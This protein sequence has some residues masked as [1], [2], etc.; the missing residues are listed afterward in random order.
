VAVPGV[1]DGEIDL[2]WDDNTEPD[3]DYY[4]VERA[5][6]PGFA[7]SDSFIA[8]DSDYAD[9][10]LV[11]GQ[12]YYYRVFANDL[13][14]H[15]SDASDIASAVAADGPPAAPTGLVAAPG[16]GEGE[17]T[18]SWNANSEPD[19]DHYRLER[20]LAPDFGPGT[21]PFDLPE[22]AY[23]DSGLVP[24]T[25]Y[26]YRVIAVD[27]GMNESPP[28]DV[29]SEVALDL[30]P[31]PP[32]GLTA[33]SGPGEGEIHLSW[34]ANPEPDID[35][36]LLERAT[37]PE[38]EPGSEPF[39]T[40]ATAYQDSGLVPGE[41]YYYR[42]SAIDA[43]EH[44]SDPSEV[45]SAV[46]LDVAPA[47]PTG[48][49]AAPSGDW[50]V[51][52]TWDP[53]TEPDLDRYRLER[54]T[55]DVFGAGTVSFETTEES[56]LDSGLDVG[57]TYYY[58]LFA[59]DVLENESAP[60]DTVAHLFEGTDVPEELV[61]SVSFIGP[62]PFSAEA[63]VAYTVPSDGASVTMSVFDVRG[64][65]VRTLVDRNHAGGVYRAAW[66]GRDAAGHQVAS[67]IYFF[68]IAVGDLERI[69]K[70]VLLR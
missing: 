16:P 61:A 34:N 57:L 25:L 47:A 28:S 42:V 27:A 54:D 1:A 30:V 20:C 53:N 8:P 9:S 21:D 52:L 15:E 66:D 2:D 68:R 45:V 36:Y 3:I 43:T 10:G 11:P 31:T 63:A 22:P 60:S 50:D 65:H 41:T 35:R 59:I 44:T 17:I 58:R 29:V 26:Y 55:T 23:H 6:N 49:T 4:R 56:Y 37:N 51:L 18:L 46:A 13:T 14:G 5:D 12:T 48:L 64:R 40:P 69:R 32:T 19:F 67:G 70:V 62:N 39:E 33:V 38:F 24:G 7:G